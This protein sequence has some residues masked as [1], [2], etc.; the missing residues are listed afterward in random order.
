ME[1]TYENKYLNK[2]KCVK[3]VVV[4]PFWNVIPSCMTHPFLN[5]NRRT[6]GP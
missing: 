5:E 6:V 3:E 4:N 1:K 2:N